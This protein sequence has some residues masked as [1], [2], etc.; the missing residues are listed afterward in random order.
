VLVALGVQPGDRV[1]VPP[2]TMASTTLA[3]LHAGA[4]PEYV[5]VDA[6]WWMMIPDTVQR[7][8]GGKGAVSV[9][10]PVSLYG[11]A[12]Q[13]TR[14]IG[15]PQPAY[16]DDA[17]QTLNRRNP[18]AAFT[19]YSF[20]ASKIL[21]A[22]EGGMLVTDDESLALRARVFS[23]LGYHPG[24]TIE[25][26]KHPTAWRHQ[27]VGYNY[28]MADCQAALLLPQLERADEILAARRY[29]AECYRQAIQWCDWLTPQYVPEGWPH[30]WWTFGIAVRDKA[31]WAPFVQAI[32]QAGGERP[33]AAW[34]ITYQE[35]AF[36]HLAPDGTCP[37][38]EDLQPRLVQLATNHDTAGA[39]R[40]AECLQRAMATCGF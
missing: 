26:L 39:E 13:L 38:A 3:V 9:L 24:R 34:R 29:S 30:S 31:M 16:V 35:P 28:R 15:G 36:R 25:D 14:H 33:Y 27:M 5:D 19:S 22:G 4:V 12:A 8:V 10:M 20:Q 2:L 7:L 21:S 37:V 32:E 11:M 23:R 1:A 6:R 17:A 40:A 18:V